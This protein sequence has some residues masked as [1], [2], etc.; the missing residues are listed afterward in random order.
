MWGNGA[1]RGR[2]LE[3]TVSMSYVDL[4]AT[5][6][7]WPYEPEKIS[8][9]KILSADDAIRVQ[10][11]VE[12]GVIQMESEGR[13]DAVRPHGCATLLDYHK[14]RLA[15]FEA[16][17]GTTLGFGL[18]PLEC[19]GLRTEASLFYRRY[20]AYFVLEEYDSVLRD[21]SH[22]LAIFDFSRDYAL[23]L[24]DRDALEEF[25]PYVRMMQARALAYRSMEEGEPA[26][27]L[28]HVNRG[29]LDI[30][31]YFD[32]AG[33][34]EVLETSEELKILK[35]LATELNIQLPADSLLSTRRALR[36]AI[37]AERFEEAARLRDDLQKRY[38]DLTHPVSDVKRH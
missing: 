24:D 30:R 9:R 13:P 27:A 19:E 25:R 11:R 17:N 28:A 20:I 15:R 7:D 4:H 33:R 37:E 32:D 23:E 29:I 26:S 6:R 16:K 5:L 36:D 14:K 31:S 1:P 34:P 35:N 12:L 18:T 10:M 22:S 8:V 2:A 3:G 38:P 21:A